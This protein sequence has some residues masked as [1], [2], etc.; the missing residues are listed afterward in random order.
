MRKRE[1]KNGKVHPL[2]N[3]TCIPYFL[4]NGFVSCVYCSK[5]PLYSDSSPYSLL[6][7]YND[8]KAL[9]LHL[10]NH[11]LS[12]TGEESVSK[13]SIVRLIPEIPRLKE[14]ITY[15]IIRYKTSNFVMYTLLCY[16]NFS[17]LD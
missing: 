6:L 9:L 14:H 8:G 2:L 3:R 11:V 4:R 1:T 13:R 15:Y 10:F 16:V 7:S 17:Q 12:V 5:R